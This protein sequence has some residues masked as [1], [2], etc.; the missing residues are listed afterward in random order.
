M[1]IRA[2][3][4]LEQLIAEWLEFNGYFVRR[5]VRVGLL[6]HGGHEGELDVVGFHP[7][8]QHLLHV[9]A[10]TDAHTWTRREGRFE[11]KFT[12]GKKH[13][14]GQIFPW[15]P[16]STAVEQWAVLWGSDKGRGTIGGGKVVPVS[17]LY[18]L[19]ANDIGAVKHG[20]VISEQF[21]LLRTMQ[22]TIRWIS[23]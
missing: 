1:E 4:H 6:T 18:R 19:I 17:R 21:P 8:T 5:N 9:E 7:E 3:N 15:L 12:T 11:K 22:L 16:P 20:R 10:S 23:K 14:L 2:V 13:I